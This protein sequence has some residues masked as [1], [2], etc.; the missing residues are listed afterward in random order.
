MAYALCHLSLNTEARPK[1]IMLYRKDRL[2]ADSRVAIREKV[3]RIR[4][5]LKFLNNQCS[6]SQK[7]TKGSCSPLNSHRMRT[8]V[9]VTLRTGYN[10]SRSG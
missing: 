3:M 2:V 6:R 8:I 7:T 10:S 4:N 5:K 1:N 9:A